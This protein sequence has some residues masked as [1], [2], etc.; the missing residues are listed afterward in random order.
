MCASQG[1]ILKK[2]SSSIWYLA[3]TQ[4][5]GAKGGGRWGVSD[6][7]FFVDGDISCLIPIFLALKVGP[8]I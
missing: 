4:K 8:C 2:A 1:T 5:R 7:D 6:I 3:V